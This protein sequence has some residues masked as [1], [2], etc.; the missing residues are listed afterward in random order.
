M[1][2]DFMNKA[3]FL[4]SFLHDFV[5]RFRSMGFE[6][7]EMPSPSIDR[8]F[9]KAGIMSLGGTSPPLLAAYSKPSIFTPS[10]CRS[11]ARLRSP[12][13]LRPQTSRIQYDPYID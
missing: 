13:R 7:G 2:N 11:S 10:P 3:F 4:I 5:G 9:A 12:P 1:L 6:R 8:N